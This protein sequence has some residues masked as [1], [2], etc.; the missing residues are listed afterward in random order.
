MDI[1]KKI[2]KYAVARRIRFTEKAR[3]E[4]LHDHLSVEDIIE[5]LVN[6]QAIN[7]ILRS[8]SSER[9]MRREKLFVIISPNMDGTLIYTKGLFRKHENVEEYYLFISSK[10]S[11][12]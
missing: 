1:L 2:K 5:S 10:W 3:T 6:A 11:R 8:R 7:K 9:K 12:I 4:R